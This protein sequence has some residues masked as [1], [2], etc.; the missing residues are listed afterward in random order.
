METEWGRD[1]GPLLVYPKLLPKYLLSCKPGPDL[2]DLRLWVRLSSSRTY[3]LRLELYT[4]CLTLRP[5]TP[6]PLQTGLQNLQPLP[7]SVYSH[8]SDLGTSRR[9]PWPTHTKSKHRLH[10]RPTSLARSSVGPYLR[11]LLTPRGVP[12]EWGPGSTLQTV[13]LPREY[14]PL[15]SPLGD[16]EV[17]EEKGPGPDT[18]RVTRDTR[19]GQEGTR[20]PVIPGPVPCLWVRFHRR[21]ENRD[22]TWGDDGVLPPPKVTCVV[23]QW[24]VVPVESGGS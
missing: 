7:S 21:V 5:S 19:G 14:D 10:R 23:N 16:T 8:T 2:P 6:R 20:R 18:E 17:R 24:S 9:F 1:P 4:L 13:L 11:G 12:D 15:R 3:R 22:R